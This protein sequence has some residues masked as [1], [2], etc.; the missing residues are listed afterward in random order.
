MDGG[1]ESEIQILCSSDMNACDFPARLWLAVS[2]RMSISPS[3]SV[4]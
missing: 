1:F 2:S 3:T 4:M